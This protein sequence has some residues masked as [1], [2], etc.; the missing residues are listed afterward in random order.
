AVAGA[1][2]HRHDGAATAL[3]LLVAAAQV[4]RQLGLDL[5]DLAVELGDRALQV[6][7]ELLLLDAALVA[8]LR[9]LAALRLQVLQ[10][11]QDL[12][13]WVH[14]VNLRGSPLSGLFGDEVQELVRRLELLEPLGNIGLLGELRDLAQDREVLVA[15]LQGGR[16]DEEEAVHRL[17][18]D[19]LELHPLRLAP[20]RH[21]QPVHH[22]RTAVRDRDPPADARRAEVFPPLE[23]LEQDALDLLVQPQEL[24]QLLED[25]VLGLALE[26]ELDRFSIEEFPQ[27][28]CC[29]RWRR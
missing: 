5:L 12:E 18:I 26:I 27:L 25:V 10:L 8:A 21:A 17:P 28:H 29:L 3:D 7:V 1:V 24:D 13:L 22:E 4:L 9:Q 2:D 15:D 23:H 20:E 6:D 14:P 11:E 16:H 19:R